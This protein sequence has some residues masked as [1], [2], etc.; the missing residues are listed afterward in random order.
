[1]KLYIILTNINLEYIEKCAR[2]LPLL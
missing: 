1:M 2:E